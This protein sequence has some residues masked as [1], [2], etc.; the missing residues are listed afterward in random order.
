M[1][2]PPPELRSHTLSNGTITSPSATRRFTM[3]NKFYVS[4]CFE[5][6]CVLTQFFTYFLS[7]CGIK[8][9]VLFAF[10]AYRSLS[11][12]FHS[13]CFLANNPEQQIHGYRYDRF[14][15][16]LWKKS[17]R[18]VNLLFYHNKCGFVLSKLIGNTEVQK[19]LM[20]IHTCCPM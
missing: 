11:Q 2:R 9:L 17:F 18:S 10:S 19:P 20:C 13:H 15:P 8:H 4:I 1:Y 16:A 6:K 14:D 12:T 5:R 7:I 3:L